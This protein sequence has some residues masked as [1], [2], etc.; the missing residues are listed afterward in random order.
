MEFTQ[1]ALLVRFC[2]LGL[3]LYLAVAP[4]I[5]GGHLPTQPHGL[6]CYRYFCAAKLDNNW[7]LSETVIIAQRSIDV[8][9]ALESN[10]KETRLM[11]YAKLVFRLYNGAKTKEAWNPASPHFIDDWKPETLEIPCNYVQ[12]TYGHH[13]KV[14]CDDELMTFFVDNH[15]YIEH[16]GVFYGNFVV[17]P[18]WDPLRARFDEINRDSAQLFKARKNQ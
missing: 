12:L 18:A 5:C 13:I 6:S 4:P 15:G 17:G 14:E 1:P 7:Q 11:K 3:L 9:G 16:K 10:R 8:A 2:L